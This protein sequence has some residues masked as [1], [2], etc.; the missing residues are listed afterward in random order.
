ML[1]NRSQN[2]SIIQILI[3]SQSI[4]GANRPDARRTAFKETR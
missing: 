3:I 2:A 4:P 1:T